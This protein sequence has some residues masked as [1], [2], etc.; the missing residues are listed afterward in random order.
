MMNRLA[1]LNLFCA[2]AYFLLFLQAGSAAV[3]AGLLSVV[4]FALMVIVGREFPGALLRITAVC[5]AAVSFVFA[6]FLLYSGG[7][8]LA[9]SVAHSYYSVEGLLLISVNALFG[10][11][12]L[13]LS[14]LFIKRS[15]NN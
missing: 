9:D 14:G 7:H 3:M 8:I 11:G 13:A 4:L 1:Y 12:I 6:L 15:L 2:A 10:L 5:A